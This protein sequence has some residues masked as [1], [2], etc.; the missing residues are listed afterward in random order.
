MTDTDN[1][2]DRYKFP[3]VHFVEYAVSG[4]ILSAGAMAIGYLEDMQ[5]NG[6]N[7]I[8][9]DTIPSLLN[10]RVNVSTNEIETK[11]NCPAVLNG[12]TLTELPIPSRVTVLGQTYEVGDGVLEMEFTTPGVYS[13]TVESPVFRTGHYEVVV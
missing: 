12:A 5:A 2:N 13:V 6:R 3:M 8:F 10:D 1:N 7:I 11:P 9:V 4:E